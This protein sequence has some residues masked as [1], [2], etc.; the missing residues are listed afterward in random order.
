LIEIRSDQLVQHAISEIMKP[1][2]RGKVLQGSFSGGKKTEDK[3]ML[4]CM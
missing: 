2:K 3:L 1:E 4:H